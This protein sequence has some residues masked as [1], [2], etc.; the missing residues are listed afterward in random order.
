MRRRRKARQLM[1]VEVETN[2]QDG[3]KQ[4]KE[5]FSC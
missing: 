2:I 5:L 4:R 1:R 3:R